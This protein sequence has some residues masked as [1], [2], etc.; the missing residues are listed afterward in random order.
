[1][2]KVSSS[3]G[4]CCDAFMFRL[5]MLEAAVCISGRMLFSW[6]PLLISHSMKFVVISMKSFSSV[7]CHQY[8]YNSPVISPL[9]QL[10]G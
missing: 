8:R 9:K 4:F 3:V 5:S 6:C 1:M 10:E 2:Y 7:F